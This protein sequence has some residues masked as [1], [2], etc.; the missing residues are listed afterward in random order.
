M[1]NFELENLRWPILQLGDAM[2]AIVR[3]VKLSDDDKEISNPPAALQNDRPGSHSGAS[4]EALNE[5]VEIAA[6]FLGFEAEAIEAPYAEVEKLAQGAGPAMLLLPEGGILAVIKSD[7]RRATIL[8]PDLKLHRVS[9]ATIC[10]LLRRPHE[11]K[12]EG[13]VERLLVDAGTPRRKIAKA[14]AAILREQL[15]HRRVSGGWLL[16]LPMGASF[17]R[18]LSAA[19]LTRSLATLLSLRVL[20]YALLMTA[21][22][23]L[24]R[25]VLNGQF[26]QGQG[27]QFGQSGWLIAWALLL[28]TSVPFHLLAEWAQGRFAI[29]AGARLKG[30]L[31]FGA[32][33]LRPEEIRHMGAGQILGKI[34]ESHA[35]E[36]LALSGGFVALSA[37][38]ELAL[39]AM[40]LALG[41]WT[42]FILLLSYLALTIFVVL[43]YYR[44]RDA[45]TETRAT[46]TND[47]VERMVGHR[48]RLAQEGR[49]R[50]HEGEDRAVESYLTQSQAMDRASALQSAAARGWLVVGLFGLAYNF[51][52][53][54]GNRAAMALSVGGLLLGYR[55]L[56]KLAPSLS[57]LSGATIAWKQIAEI[58][59]AA[60]REQDSGSPD[61][62]A[63]PIKST[64]P[65]RAASGEGSFG[66]PGAPHNPAPEMLVEAH[67]ITFRYHERGEPT[68]R[69][70]GL[71]IR[72]GDRL[73][74]EG[75]SGG[76]KSTLASLLTGLRT[77]ESGLLLFGGLDRQTMGAAGW[78]KRVTSAP[79]FHENHILTGTFAFNLLMG[80]GWPPTEKDLAEAEEICRALGLGDLLSRMPAGLLQMVGETGWQLSHGERS[81]MFMAR[82][83]LQG[84]D[85]VILDE[86][87]GALDP[88]TLRRC[89]QTAID[90]AGTLLVIA[91]P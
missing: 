6:D 4:L 23:I 50:W 80:R 68:L 33:R 22:W 87:F 48:T 74:L 88:A 25:G 14:R 42:Q 5:W 35:I 11:I 90:R 10:S 18:Q 13:E 53:N 21:W 54:G 89:L 27:G 62:A 36:S 40:I 34:T 70:C 47:L 65:K 59:N 60:A 16:R 19:G 37:V 44:R 55:G 3:R 26:G 85:L 28:L 49:E 46:M 52:S 15:G 38:I 20:N 75:A 84:A 9:V 66:F 39:S 30:R 63:R 2:R 83:L 8:A 81:R 76:G 45:W 32:L 51:V 1:T 31:L 69:G 24:G 41:G 43:R 82:A 56:Q 12:V 73:L 57:S 77:P 67:D 64:P 71:R 79:Q 7:S 17:W 29:E 78:R 72:A 91:H 61:F 86:S 58:F